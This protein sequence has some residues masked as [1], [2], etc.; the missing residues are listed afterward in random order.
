MLYCSVGMQDRKWEWVVHAGLGTTCCSELPVSWSLVNSAPMTIWKRFSRLSWQRATPTSPE[1]PL[2]AFLG[3]AG[4][5]DMLWATERS[6]WAR[7]S[8]SAGGLDVT[9]YCM[10]RHLIMTSLTSAR[11]SATHISSRCTHNEPASP[12]VCRLIGTDCK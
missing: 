8:F 3:S 9:I 12:A 11:L 1:R 6:V 4:S 2:P 5:N 10:R 7:E